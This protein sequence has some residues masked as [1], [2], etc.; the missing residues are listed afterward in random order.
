MRYSG[1]ATQDYGHNGKVLAD[2]EDNR[3]MI[4][5]L[6]R[7]TPHDRELFTRYIYW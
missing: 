1:S 2:I 3:Y 7:L 5:D 6:S 4:P